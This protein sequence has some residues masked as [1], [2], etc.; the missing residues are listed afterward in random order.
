LDGGQNNIGAEV[1]MPAT[2]T[3]ARMNSVANT[4]ERIVWLSH[5]D[6]LG[7]IGIDITRQGSSV[8]AVQRLYQDEIDTRKL[9]AKYGPRP[10]GLP[11]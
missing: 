7:R 1:Q 10:D 11:G 6:P 4:L 2:T 3:V 9:R 5:L 8:S